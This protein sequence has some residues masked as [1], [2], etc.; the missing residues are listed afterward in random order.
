[1]W[2]ILTKKNS[3][4]GKFC[5]D[6][7]TKTIALRKSFIINILLAK[8]YKKEQQAAPKVSH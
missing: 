5:L 6:G 8:E 7:V 1:M 3:S 2:I 4:K